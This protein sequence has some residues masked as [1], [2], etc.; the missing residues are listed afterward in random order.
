M[1]TKRSKPAPAQPVNAVVCNSAKELAKFFFSLKAKDSLNWLQAFNPLRNMTIQ[2]AQ[3]HYDAARLGDTSRLHWLWQEIEAADPILG[4]CVERRTSSVVE[5]DYAIRPLA[6]GKVRG[7]DETLASDQVQMLSWQFGEAERNNLFAAIEHLAL[8]AFRNFSAVLPQMDDGDLHGFDLIDSWNILKRPGT[9][10][11]FWN[12]GAIAIGADFARLDLIPP[13]EIVA[14]AQRR[15][16]DYPAMTIYM[17]AALGE[18][19]W[20]MFV[21]RYGIPPIYLTMPDNMDPNRKVEFQTAAEQMRDGNGGALPSGTLVNIPN[22]TRGVNP[23]VDFLKHQ[24]ELLVLMATGG[25][26]TSLVGATGMGSGVSDAQSASYKAIIRR[27]AQIISAAFNKTVVARLMRHYYPGRPILASFAITG[28]SAPTPAEVFELAGKARAAG[29]RI[30]QADLEESTGS[31]LE[32]DNSGTMLAQPIPNKAQN[33]P[34]PVE[35]DDFLSVYKALQAQYKDVY[36]ALQSGEALSPEQLDTLL[37]AKEEASPALKEA[38][39]KIVATQFA[40]GVAE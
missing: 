25:T 2:Q 17:R 27:D 38:F 5:M 18:K 11:Y 32:V 7:Y 24:Q 35:S 8:A 23:F 1:K 19:K 37:K 9:D 31:T 4:L 16:I 39:E 6:D 40:E 20:G 36:E 30:A 28:E 26:L 13:E 10:E 14:V 12:P 21:D 15:A 22:E 3:N 34:A 33:K 29:Y